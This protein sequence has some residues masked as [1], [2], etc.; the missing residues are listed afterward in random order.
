MGCGVPTRSLTST[1]RRFAGPALVV[2][3][4][5]AVTAVAAALRSMSGRHTVELVAIGVG[6]ALAAGAIGAFVLR[7]LRRKA[8]AVQVATVALTAVGA[9]G[10]GAWVAARAMFISG[11][12][13]A[14]LDVVMIAAG[15]AGVVAALALG[16]RVARASDALADR[17]RSLGASSSPANGS[18]R[19]QRSPAPAELARLE[20]ELDETSTRLEEARRRERAMEQSR[21]EL[22]AW[23]SHDL[24]TPLAGIRAMTEALEDG[25]V[26]DPATVASYH[27]ALRT[28]TDRL[29]GLVDDLFELSRAEAGV[30]RLQHERVSLGDLVSDALAGAMPVADAKGVRLVGHLDGPAP[31]LTCSAPDVLRVLRNLLENAIRHT[32]SDGTVVVEAG[33]DES[34]PGAFFSVVDSGGGIPEPD[35]ERVFDTAYRADPARTPGGGAGLGLTIARGLVEAHRGE[36]SVRNDNGGARFTVRLP[37]D[38]GEEPT[39]EATPA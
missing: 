12:D 4:G 2:L 24:R 27:A 31:D 17:A 21:R 25:V 34:G 37:L 10:L 30:L 1:S 33:M 38:A 19:D 13:A 39:A 18:E 14:T 22:I 8:L 36:I 29:S 11:H 23:V 5:T 35:L 28:E 6:A 20:H 26:A 16:D 9:V 15:T 3:V 32:P 7:L